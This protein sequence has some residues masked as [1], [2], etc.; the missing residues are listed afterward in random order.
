MIDSLRRVGR[1]LTCALLGHEIGAGQI[2][3]PPA[4]DAPII[5]QCRRC[6]RTPP[7]IIRW[8]P[9]GDEV[10]GVEEETRPDVGLLGLC[11]MYECSEAA[12][13]TVRVQPDEF[14]GLVLDIPVCR[15]DA[16]WLLEADE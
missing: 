13:E 4:E 12:Q 9:I 10:A 16:E 14:G 5:I 1:R 11:A 7:I 15:N 2:P 8:Q 3:T 6:D